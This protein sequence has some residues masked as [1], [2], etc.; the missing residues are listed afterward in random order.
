MD[1]PFAAFGGN[2]IEKSEA[3]YLIRSLVSFSCATFVYC[4]FMYLAIMATHFTHIEK[5]NCGFSVWVTAYASGIDSVRLFEF[6]LVSEIRSR[7][8]VSQMKPVAVDTFQPFI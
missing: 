3:F 5:F 1:V 8:A 7:R 2:F 6:C 4:R